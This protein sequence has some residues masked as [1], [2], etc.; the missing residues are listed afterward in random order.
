MQ[1]PYNF[2]MVAIHRRHPK[3]LS[4]PELLDAYIEHRKEVVINRSTFELQKAQERE[5]VVKGL[6]KALSIL[7]EVIAVIR[8]SKDKRDAKDNLISEFAFTEPQAEA[9]VSLQLYRLT[10]TDITA[11]KAEEEELEKKSRG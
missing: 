9:I 6:I 2:N 7:D 3:L 10:N 5:H 8:A 11:L 1:V 4:L